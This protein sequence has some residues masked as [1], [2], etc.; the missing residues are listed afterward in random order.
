MITTLRQQRLRLGRLLSVLALLA[1][2]GGQVMEAGHDHGASNPAA[3]C[4]LCQ[5]AADLAAV[6][7]SDRGAADTSA[8][9]C[10][11]LQSTG[12]PASPFT[13]YTARGPPLSA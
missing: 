5:G 6:S 1:L 4:L 10:S 3:E 9:P 13:A 12:A 2:L 8:A 7:S 11:P